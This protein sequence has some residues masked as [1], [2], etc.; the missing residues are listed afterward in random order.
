MDSTSSRHLLCCTLS[1]VLSA[2]LAPLAH[3]QWT[4][5]TPEELSMTSQPEVPGAPAVYLFREET[6]EDKLHMFSIY[7]R[8]K[9]LT[10]RDKEFA[11]VELPYTTGEGGRT[12][13]EIQGRT[14]HPDGSI[15]SFTGKPYQKLIEREHRSK[16]MAEVFSLPDVEVGSIIEYRYKLRYG[17]HILYNPQWYIQSELWTRKAHYQWKPID[18]NRNMNVTGERGQLKTIIA[19]TPILPPGAEVKQTLLPPTTA[20]L[21]GQVVLDL[22]VH[23]IPPAPSEEHMP[24]MQSFSYRVLFYYS[25]FR[26][27]DEFWKSEGK[28]WANSRDKFIGPGSGV[29][30]AVKDLITPS[31]T[32]DQ[33]LRKLYAAIMQLENTNYTRQHS[34][35]EEK[36]EGF[37]EIHNTDDV[38]TR[39]RGN[40]DQLAALFVAMARAAG[41]KAY[42]M[43]VTN[44]D[45]SIFFKSYLSLDQL[46]D[47]IAIVN[48]DG[49]EQFFDPGSRYC[50]YQHLAWNHTMTQGLRQVDGG[51][52]LAGTPRETYGFSHVQRIAELKLDDQRNVTGTIKMTY[53]GYS[54]LGWRQR[55]LTGDATSLEHELRTGVEHLIPDGMQV[56]IASIEKLAEYEQP[57]VVNFAVTGGLGSST[58]KRLLLPVDLFEVNSKTTFPKEKRE[59]PVAFSYP[60]V[61]QDAV[62]ITFPAT[63]SIESLPTSGKVPLRNLAGYDITPSSTPTSF[64]VHRNYILNEVLHMPNEY[65]ELRKFYTDFESKDQESVVLTTTPSSASKPTPAAN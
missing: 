44:R 41:M 28:Y 36:A 23:D 45:R 10:E 57:L 12:V 21:N 8:L 54:A 38:W 47:D 39:K 56:K 19:W 59:V 1:V 34:N 5:P 3:A 61:V 9:V 31:D 7:I 24:P 17:D 25:A 13:E 35:S 30:A 52:A 26:T 4:A 43:T 62:R 63:L 29:S 58:G 11:N 48:V 18:L 22:D 51:S 40:N 33:K 14:I 42:L 50:P 16:F 65:G 2:L 49:K 37:K 27:A 20:F 64:T 46:N 32:Q 60:H 53:M 55:S 6:T 15:I